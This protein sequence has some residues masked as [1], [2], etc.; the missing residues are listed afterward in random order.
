MQKV[1]GALKLE[2]AGSRAIYAEK[3]AGPTSDTMN[4]SA[5]AFMK[6]GMVVSVVGG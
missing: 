1:S 3:N 2:R 4:E 5:R 6:S